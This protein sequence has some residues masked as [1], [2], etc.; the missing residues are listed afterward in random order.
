VL[1]S[2]TGRAVRGHVAVTLLA[3]LG[4]EVLGPWLLSTIY[5]QEFLG[6]AKVFRILI[7]AKALS[8]T[9]EV[10]H[11][12]LMALDRPGLDSVIQGIGVGLAAPLILVLTPR[13][14]LEGVGLALLVSAAAQFVL[15]VL[16]F[17]LILKARVPRLWP[18]Q[19]D[20]AAIA[21]AIAAA[22]S[23]SGE[24]EHHLRRRRDG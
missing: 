10:L 15:A 24:S 7:P 1:R 13:Y 14:G 11:S 23:R 4:L 2:V 8:G 16:S 18:T 19:A 12:S 3:A 9:A 5:G 6:A 17:P 20:V 22:S 21:A